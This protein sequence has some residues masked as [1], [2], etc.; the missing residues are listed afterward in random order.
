MSLGEA[1]SG[2][3][4]TTAENELGVVIAYSE[5]SGAK[6]IPVRESVICPDFEEITYFF[7]FTRCLGLRCSVLRRT[8]RRTGRSPRSVRRTWHHWRRRSN[9][10]KFCLFTVYWYFVI[11]MTK[12]NRSFFD[13]SHYLAIRCLQYFFKLFVFMFT[14]R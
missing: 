8:A 14:D 3:L 4:V 1:S 2:Y 5:A 12:H 9:L 10:K 11:K 13:A 7:L 6:M